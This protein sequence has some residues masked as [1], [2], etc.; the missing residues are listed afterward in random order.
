M[1][2][3]ACGAL[4]F[5]L[6]C[7]FLLSAW[8]TQINPR[9]SRK[10][11]IF[12]M[13]F[14][15]VR[16]SSANASRDDKQNFWPRSRKTNL[17]FLE[18]FL[19]TGTAEINGNGWMKSSVVLL[20]PVT[21]VN[22]AILCVIVPGMQIR[23]ATPP[24]AA[25]DKAI[26]AS[27]PV[28]NAVAGAPP[29]S[30]PQN[31][32]KGTVPTSSPAGGA[33]TRPVPPAVQPGLH[34]ERQTVSASGNLRIQYLRD[35][36]QGMRE[37]VLQDPHDPSNSCILAQYSGSAWPV[38]SP[39]DQWIALNTRVEGEAAAQLY[40]R[41]STSPLKYEIPSELSTPGGDLEDVI[42]NNYLSETQQDP[43]VDRNQVTI[44]AATW[45]PDSQKLTFSVTPKPVKDNTTPPAPWTCV[46]NVSTSQ[47]ETPGTAEERA[48]TADNTAPAPNES[49]ASAAKPAASPADAAP[50]AESADLEGE[51]YPATRQDQLTV[52][53][54]N[55]L[56]LSDVRYAINEM[57]A[58]HGA[59]FKDAKIKHTFAQFSWYQPRADVSFETIES[60]F[61]ELEKHNL[62]VLKRVR[63]AKIKIAHRDD[64]RPLRGQRVQ[65]ETAGQRFLRS[66]L[67]GVSNQPDG[68]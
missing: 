40:H 27:S 37:I 63:E 64:S 7:F 11:S 44:D 28:S 34:L 35:R 20:I 31:A 59:A 61:S 9:N 51:K 36:Q 50:T 16:A 57:F 56:S 68:Q 10:K 41:V 13:G 65:E 53:E 26:A 43:K 21:V 47:I 23:A 54:A 12:F 67:Q 55:E 29:A 25:G 39:D 14:F 38:V 1:L 17:R 19:L 33:H 49:S 8:T 62:D 58:R 3:G 30:S 4:P 15:L 42:W 2:D 60:E 5:E 18:L 24:A 6:G 52:S 45:E 22:V 46:Y 32:V 66:V 48:K